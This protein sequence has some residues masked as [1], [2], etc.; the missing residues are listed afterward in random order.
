M[1]HA[2]TLL[3]IILLTAGCGG[4][5]TQEAEQKTGVIE[6][7]VFIS[8]ERGRTLKL[9]DRAVY[10]IPKAP[11]NSHIDS[12]QRVRRKRV[13]RMAPKVASFMEK[14]DRRVDEDELMID[15][16]ERETELLDSLQTRI[17]KLLQTSTLSH[18][19]TDLPPASDTTRT[20]AN[21]RYRLEVPAGNSY[22]VTS[23][24]S[25]KLGTGFDAPVEKIL[26]MKDVSVS[27]DTTTRNL[28]NSAISFYSKGSITR[29]GLVDTSVVLYSSEGAE[30]QAGQFESTVAGDFSML[31]ADAMGR[32]WE[33]MLR[34]S[35]LD[36]D[37]LDAIQRKQLEQQ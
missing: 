34:L 8:L 36:P 1:R 20:D 6:G 21:G 22:Y 13:D 29:G 33:A 3:A 2:L 31:P 17:E 9:S 10:A 27:A 28:S 4:T 16:S 18:F 14:V 11:L 32:D 26:W 24:A 12:I 7:Q 25:R 19:L 15:R 37:S 5:E 23:S 30:M 35:A